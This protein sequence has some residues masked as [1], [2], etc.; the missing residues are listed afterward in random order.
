M[1]KQ[2]SK[3][4]RVSAKDALLLLAALPIL[5][6]L[7][8]ALPLLL[9]SWLVYS[10]CLHIVIWVWWC[11]RGRDVLFVYSDSPI[12]R[13]YLETTV[14][15]RITRRAIVLNWSERKRWKVSLATMAF[16]HFGGHREFNPLAVVF[17]PLR[18]TRA[19]R[20][21]KPFKDFKHGNSQ[22]LERLQSE[23]FKCIGVGRVV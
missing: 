2:E 18:L 21:W 12:W 5:A 1:S 9:V 14:L 4:R 11:A 13:E 10:I 20:F 6:M 19:F 7:L 17:R 23:F 15:P 8:V 16:R 3:Q 22:S